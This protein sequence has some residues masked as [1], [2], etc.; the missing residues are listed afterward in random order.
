M[1]TSVIPALLDALVV[2]LDAGLPQVLV[3]YGSGITDDPGD[4]LMIG[5]DDPDS[6]GAFAD[7]ADSQ[8]TWAGLGNHARDQKGNI[9]CT[10]HSGVGETDAQA[11]TEAAY[12]TVAAVDTYLRANP[13][14]GGVISTGWAIHGSSERL[15]MAQTDSGAQARVT[16]QIYFQARI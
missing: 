4:Y 2:Q 3:L 1:A 8:A 5:V 13:T 9:W 10:A 11:A 14:V 7:A 16:F 6:S 15:S 12:A